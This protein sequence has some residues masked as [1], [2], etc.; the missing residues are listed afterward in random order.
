MKICV[1]GLGCI[2]LP[3]AC[4]FANANHEVIG[5][6]VNQETI[7]KLKEID[8]EEISKLMRRR[9]VVDSRNILDRERRAGAG[10]KVKVLGD[11]R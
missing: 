6:G 2:G 5:A 1:I 3:T 10:F 9:N 8:P 7:K 11:W 4:L